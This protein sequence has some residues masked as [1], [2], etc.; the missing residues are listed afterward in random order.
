MTGEDYLK[1]A[2]RLRQVGL[3]NG[4]VCNQS[5][6]PFLKEKVSKVYVKIRYGILEQTMNLLGKTGRKVSP[7]AYA[8]ANRI[9]GF[10]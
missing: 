5:H 10:N 6:A 1:F 8:V 2:R 4:I 9:F 7:M 3:D